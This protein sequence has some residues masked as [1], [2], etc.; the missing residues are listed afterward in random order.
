VGTLENDSQQGAVNLRF[1]TV[2]RT[3]ARPAQPEGDVYE[4]EYYLSDNQ[5]GTQ[6]MRR[7]WPNPDEDSKPGGLLTAIASD[8]EMFDVRYFDGLKWQNEWD[9][10]KNELPELVEVSIAAKAPSGKKPF[11]ESFLTNFETNTGGDVEIIE[12][13]NQQTE[14][15]GSN[16]K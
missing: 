1:Y 11:V 6:L 4:V 10:D 8:I 13:D 2:S 9:I 14:T 7:Y 16:Q 3:N 5:Q 15:A 12:T